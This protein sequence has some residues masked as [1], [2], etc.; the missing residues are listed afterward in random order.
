[1]KFLFKNIYFVEY[2]PTVASELVKYRCIFSFLKS[3]LRIKKIKI[4]QGSH[5]D[6][7]TSYLICT[8][9]RS[10]VKWLNINVIYKCNI[11]NLQMWEI[12][13]Q[14]INTC[15]RNILCSFIC[16]FVLLIFLLCGDLNFWFNAFHQINL[17]NNYTSYFVKTWSNKKASNFAVYIIKFTWFN[18]S[19]GSWLVDWLN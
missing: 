10:Y 11:I 7:L 8:C 5:L 9:E 2:L 14:K 18:N 16:S 19:E 15:C 3:V 1:M 17:M 4:I 12:P 13:V 6:V